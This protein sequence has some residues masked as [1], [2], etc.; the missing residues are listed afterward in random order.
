MNYLKMHKD[1]NLKLYNVN[2][3]SLY[4]KQLIRLSFKKILYFKIVN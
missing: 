4:F 3:K 2:E 1:H